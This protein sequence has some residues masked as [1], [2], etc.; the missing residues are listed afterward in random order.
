MKSV[1]YEGYQYERRNDVRYLA[2]S[3]L[4]FDVWARYVQEGFLRSECGNSP[5]QVKN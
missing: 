1:G 5:S 3:F 4:S 2:Y